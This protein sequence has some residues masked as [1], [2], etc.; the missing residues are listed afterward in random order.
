[1][2]RMVA[3]RNF[4]LAEWFALALSAGILVWT[5]RAG[6]IVFPDT[7]GY[8]SNAAF[9]P[10][11]YPVFLNL[12]G[13]SFT[14]VALVQ[15]VLVLSVSAWAGRVLTRRF[16]LPAWSF[17]LL[18]FMLVTPL[19]PSK[20]VYASTHGLIGRSIITEAVTYAVFI[21]A[22]AALVESV[23]SPRLRWFLAFVVLSVCSTWLRSQMVFMLVACVP[24]IACASILRSKPRTAAILLAALVAVA[25]L[26]RGAQKIYRAHA[27]G[28]ELAAHGGA[29]AL[30]VPALYLSSPA[31][32]DA[33]AI[34][35]DK[36]ALSKI[37]DRFDKERLFASC[38]SETDDTAQAYYLKKTT[39]LASALND[40]FKDGGDSR[41]FARRLLP[42][43]FRRHAGPLVR[44]WAGMF[45]YFMDFRAGLFFGLL[46]IALLRRDRSRLTLALAL[47]ALLSL[48]N[49][50]ALALTYSSGRYLM[51]T[52]TVE[53]VMAVVALF[54]WA[55]PAQRSRKDSSDWP[56]AA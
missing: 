5:A 43:L 27:S 42:I 36:T 17:A 38:A 20:S 19:L 14:A 18:Y 25:G 12:F 32:V 50:G 22:F 13:G 24:V 34:P 9:R 29:A 23:F 53:Q 44:F 55:A 10:F 1:M 2:D 52:N 46:F 33:V 6:F 49:R 8:A 30:L 45:L 31:D 51:Y 3:R 7:A 4:G 15:T 16:A 37:Y 21:A 35:E 48:L 39:P 54:Y 47:T 41:G 56:A 40:A 28:G 26:G 11:G